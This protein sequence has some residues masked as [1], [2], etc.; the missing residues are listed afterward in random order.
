MGDHRYRVHPENGCNSS[1]K[2]RRSESSSNGTDEGTPSPARRTSYGSVVGLAAGAL[3]GRASKR[4]SKGPAQRRRMSATEKPPLKGFGGSS[5][6][7]IEVR[8]AFPF[9]P[10]HPLKSCWDA[11]LVLL[12]I[13][14][15][16]VAPI[17][18][19]F[20]EDMAGVGWVATTTIVADVLFCLD[21]PL[22][23]CMYA[24]LAPFPKH[25]VPRPVRSHAAQGLLPVRSAR[26][27]AAE[28]QPALPDG[29][30][31]GRPPRVGAL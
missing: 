31:L 6:S 22:Q 29:M 26:L 14:G 27:Q 13:F 25:T 30:V 18:L 3:V 11:A 17:E 1:P 5:S 2:E 12:A 10:D 15:I 9:R 16:F 23:F 20:H 21:V 28:D 8:P 7:E 19:G 4:L 24:S